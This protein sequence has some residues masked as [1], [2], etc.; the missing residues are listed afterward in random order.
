VAPPGTSQTG[1]NTLPF[2]KPC[3]CCPLFFAPAGLANS[4]APQLGAS[5]LA[6][7]TCISVF[8]SPQHLAGIRSPVLCM[9]RTGFSHTRLGDTTRSAK[10][11]CCQVLPGPSRDVLSIS[12]CLLWLTTSR[13][14]SPIPACLLCLSTTDLSADELADN[15][16]RT[17]TWFTIRHLTVALQWRWTSCSQV[18]LHPR[19]SSQ[20][21][22]VCEALLKVSWSTAWCSAST[23]NTRSTRKQY[24]GAAS[25][26]WHGSARLP[27]VTIVMPQLS[28]GSPFHAQLRVLLENLQAL[29]AQM[30]Q[31][32]FSLSCTN[33]YSVLHAG[34]HSP[35]ASDLSVSPLCDLITAPMPQLKCMTLHYMQAL[36]A[37]MSAAGCC[38]PTWWFLQV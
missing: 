37:P 13:D 26:G 7:V 32:T 18:I 2:N 34:T 19:T 14:V 29:R 36:R 8:T 22:L 23:P 24:T 11:R 9:S 25:A 28:L 12:A 21:L 27:G 20:A 15:R 4:S 38:V 31:L 16:S 30:L 1:L 6:G 17:A 5:N 33:P 35:N 10:P 3:P